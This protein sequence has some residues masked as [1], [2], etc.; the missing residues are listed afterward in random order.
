ME[1]ELLASMIEYKII[2]VLRQKIL[3]CLVFHERPQKNAY[4]TSLQKVPK[5]TNA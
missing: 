5:Y 4:N 3:R 1:E 2:Y